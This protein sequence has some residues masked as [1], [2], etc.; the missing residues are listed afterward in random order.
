MEHNMHRIHTQLKNILCCIRVASV[1][2]IIDQT[3]W[4]R[5]YAVCCII[6]IRKHRD[7]CNIM[8]RYC[9]YYCDDLVYLNYIYMAQSGCRFISIETKTHC[10]YNF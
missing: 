5:I 3:L 8:Y 10:L 2:D 7:M 6:R 4:H 9:M 1:L